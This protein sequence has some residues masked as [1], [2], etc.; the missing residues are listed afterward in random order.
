[1][2]THTHTHTHTVGRGTQ[3]L[4]ETESV[5]MGFADRVT[6]VLGGN[7]ALHTKAGT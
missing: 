3:F 2:H 1:M 7:Q 6:L 4:A 5:E